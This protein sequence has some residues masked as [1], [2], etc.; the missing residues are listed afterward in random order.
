[1]LRWSF[2]RVC[3]LLVE[4]RRA[5]RSMF[6]VVF[7]HAQSKINKDDTFLSLSQVNSEFLTDAIIQISATFVRTS[8][9]PVKG[10]E[11]QWDLL[12][13]LFF[14][15]DNFASSISWV[16]MFMLMSV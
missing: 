13:I 6:E 14:V 12:E 15:T 1:M 3:T 7:I 4:S 2:V 11:V 9:S 16:L 8:F 10:M 5:Q